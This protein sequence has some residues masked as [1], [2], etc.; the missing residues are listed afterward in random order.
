M[1]GWV[2]VLAAAGGVAAVARWYQKGGGVSG[3]RGADAQE[4]KRVR[5]QA[6]HG[7][8]VSEHR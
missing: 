4:V 8:G 6:M 5:V 7:G 1:L 3:Y 2:I